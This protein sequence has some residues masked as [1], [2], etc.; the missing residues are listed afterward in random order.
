MYPWDTIRWKGLFYWIV[1]LW[2]KLFIHTVLNP[3]PRNH[4]FIWVDL[5]RKAIT[6]FRSTFKR[7]KMCCFSPDEACLN[8]SWIRCGRRPGRREEKQSEADVRCKSANPECAPTPF[9]ISYTNSLTLSYLNVYVLCSKGVHGIFVKLLYCLT[10]CQ[11][12]C[13][14]PFVTLSR[15]NFMHAISTNNLIPIS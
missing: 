3:F 15:K 2:K 1:W 14:T 8:L 7:I 11:T 5:L 13:I 4:F 12:F 9:F 6:F 10:L